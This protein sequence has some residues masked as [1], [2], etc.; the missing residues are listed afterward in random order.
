MRDSYPFSFLQTNFLIN[1]PYLYRYENSIFI[2]RFFNEGE[3]FIS[4]FINFKKYPDNEL[5]D[6]GEGSLWL[7]IKEKSNESQI[8]SISE[9]TNNQ[10]CL[11]TSTVL[12]DSLKIK[13]KSDGV[14]RI[15]DPNRFVLE[16]TK[17]LTRVKGV[18]L[19]NCIY[20][21]KREI[22]KMVNAI[23]KDDNLN[24]NR[25]TSIA[26]I[27]PLFLKKN[28]H[29]HQSEFRII[30]ITDRDVND[31]LII[32]CPEAIKYCDKIFFPN[33]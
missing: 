28:I 5:G 29:Q 14:F 9:A 4:S 10:Y 11:S 17:S 26:G 19:G 27:E 25:A 2:D 23:S 16:I 12:D 20:V 3:L 13:F 30:W 21:A 6:P 1:V 32:R 8:L 15:I 22:T 33:D 7:T 31:G 24:I 18:Y